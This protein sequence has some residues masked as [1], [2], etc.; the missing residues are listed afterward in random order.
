MKN[1]LMF[2]LAALLLAFSL[3][4]CGGGGQTTGT[5]DTYGSAEGSRT[6]GGAPPASPSKKPTGPRPLDRFDGPRDGTSRPVSTIPKP[7]CPQPGP[8]KPRNLP[9]IWECC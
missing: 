7:Y 3:T 2:L 5:A 9:G 8:A 1:T 4:A 6:D